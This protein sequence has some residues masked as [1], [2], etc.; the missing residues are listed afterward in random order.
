MIQIDP[1]HQSILL[2]ALEDLMYKVSMEL[3][4]YKGGPMDKA[5][6]DLTNKQQQ[7]EALQHLIISHN[8]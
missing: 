7:I 1:K 2:E 8:K 5:R 3:E 4:N 6:K